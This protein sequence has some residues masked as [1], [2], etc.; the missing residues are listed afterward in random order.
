MGNMIINTK[1][2]RSISQLLKYIKLYINSAFK[3]LIIEVYLIRH[4]I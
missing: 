4:I 2:Y 1:K 3:K